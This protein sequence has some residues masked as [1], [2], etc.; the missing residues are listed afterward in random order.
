MKGTNV[1]RADLI[2]L[3]GL[4]AMLCGAL[5]VVGR[6]RSSLEAGPPFVLLLVAAM[7]ATGCVA[8]LLQ[9]ERYGRPG[10][11]ASL[12]SFVGLALVLWANQVINS[13]RGTDPRADWAFTAL[14]LG[15]LAATVGLVVLA[16][17]TTN[18]RLLPWW[19]GV[20]LVAG[21]PFGVLLLM[22]PPSMF[23]ESLLEGPWQLAVE[24][25]V[26]VPW[27]LVG[28]AVFWAGSRRSE[29]HSR[30]R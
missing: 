13:I 28:Y 21:S 5:Y 1:K 10:V 26:G 24:A 12:V 19:C 29:Q 23:S 15:I 22:M 3:G 6:Y 14:I 30:V 7:V 4:V 18:A 11:L 9:R 16:I 8:F 25:L 17:V 27:V 2:R 20:A